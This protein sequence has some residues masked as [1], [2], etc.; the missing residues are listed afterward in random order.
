M[1]ILD[2]FC[3]AGG[4]AIGLYQA[5]PTAEIIGVDIKPQ[6]RYPFRFIQADVLALTFNF[7]IFDLIWASPPCQA[8]SASTQ[9]WRHKGREYVDL[10]PASRKLLKESRVPYVIENV[11]GAPLVSPTMLCGAMFSLKVY[12]HRLFETSF[13]LRSP[14]HE[15]H[16]IAQTKVGRPPREGEFCNP[17][18]HFPN[19]KYHQEA[20]GI[21]W[22]NKTEL[23]QA[24]PPA[25][26]EWVAKQFDQAGW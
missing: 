8:Y 6:P 25:Y 9:E 10:V 16:K 1:K 7:S 14:P 15:P 26:S 12:R 3:G 19:L 17:V 20:M 22:M 5:W 23:A 21:S 2:L 4:A 13:T 24:I 11:V 18:G